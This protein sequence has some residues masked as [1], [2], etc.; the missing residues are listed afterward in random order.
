MVEI[1][2]LQRPPP[3]YEDSCMKGQ[4]TELVEVVQEGMMRVPAQ[5]DRHDITEA[6]Q[7][8]N[9]VFR[10]QTAER[11][12]VPDFLACNIFAC[13]CCC[14]PIG[15]IGI[16]FS[17]L[18]NSAKSAGNPRQ[19]KCLSLTAGIPFTLSFIGGI[20]LISVVLPKYLK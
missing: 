13:L 12:D 17:V 11:I 6:T 7:T 20:I 3:P 18:C 15:L 2:E 9:V 19:A 1:I 4:T 14:W 8:E 10:Q 16:L 5:R